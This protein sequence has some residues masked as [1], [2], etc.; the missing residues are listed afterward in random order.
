M[1]LVIIAILTL[2]IAV[3]AAFIILVGINPPQSAVAN[4]SPPVSGPQ[5]TVIDEKLLTPLKLFSDKQYFNLRT[6]DNRLSVVIVDVTIKY[7]NKMDGIKD[8]AAKISLHEDNLKEIVCNYFQS[9]TYDEIKNLDTKLQAKEDLK[10]EMNSFLIATI[11][12]DTDRRKVVE[13]VYEVVFSGWN[14][15]QQ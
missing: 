9:M 10:D 3:L 14:Y 13:I 4:G 1:L 6:D 2:I 7:I 11:E 5:A 8:V 15:Q 12:K